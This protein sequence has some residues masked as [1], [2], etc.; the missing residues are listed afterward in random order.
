[1]AISTNTEALIS[2]YNQK[3]SLDTQQLS[4][5]NLIKEGY[6]IQTEGENPIRIWGPEEVIDYYNEPI[7]KLDTRIVQLNNQIVG[8]QNTILNVGQAANAVGCGTT[9][10]F[11]AYFLAFTGF[12]TVTVYADTVPYRGYTYTSPN[13]FSPINGTLTSGNAG[14]GTETL[15]GITSIGV[16]YGPIGTGGICAGYATSIT[17]L[18]AQ[19]VGIQSTRNALIVKANLLKSGRSQYQLQNYAYNQSTSVVNSQITKSNTIIN[20]LEDPANEE[21]L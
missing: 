7:E 8:L 17:N 2:L 13:P 21:W 18:N 15:T 5:I 1:M 3:V 4:Q 12:S 10:Y 14:I 20:F 19:I 6:N 9:G 16:Y 11:V